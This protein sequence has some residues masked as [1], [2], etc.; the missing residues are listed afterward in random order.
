[1]NF[2]RISDPGCRLGGYLTLKRLH[3]NILPRLRGLP[4][5]EDLATCLGGAPHLSC[6]RNQIKMRDYMDREVT[7]PKRVTLP[8]WGLPPPFKQALTVHRFEVRIGLS[9][10]YIIF[11]GS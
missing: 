8:T 10:K 11:Q 1:M 6:K 4:G 3:G 2:A 5:L 7:P 9:P